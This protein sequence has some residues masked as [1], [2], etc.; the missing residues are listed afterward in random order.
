[1]Q[2]DD[3]FPLNGL[4]ETVRTGTRKCVSALQRE[5]VEQMLSKSGPAEKEK[6]PNRS[7]TTIWD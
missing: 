5:Y 4:A 2:P 1:M 3:D 6:I 7:S